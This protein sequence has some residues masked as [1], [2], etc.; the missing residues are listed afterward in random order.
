MTFLRKSCTLQRFSV[1]QGACVGMLSGG[2]LP[3]QQLNRHLYPGQV[4]GQMSAQMGGQMGGHLGGRAMP[5]V[6]LQPPFQGLA[7]RALAGMEPFNNA[8]PKP[9]ATTQQ[10]PVNFC[11]TSPLS[12]MYA[13]PLCPWSAALHDTG[14]V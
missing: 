4:S 5:P 11:T 2:G 9:Q 8:Q 13:Q 7:E 3:Q 12:G 6:G 10:V 14:Y 1:L